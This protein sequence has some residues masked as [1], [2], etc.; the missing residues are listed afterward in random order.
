MPAATLLF[1]A[2]YQMNAWAESK[3]AIRTADR[4]AL[5]ERPTT[6]RPPWK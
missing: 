6:C 1:I 3:C 2:M 4:M 5:P